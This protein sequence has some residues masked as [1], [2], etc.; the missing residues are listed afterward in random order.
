MV[1]IRKELLEFAVNYIWMQVAIKHGVYHDQDSLEEDMW[2]LVV[3][4]E[5]PSG[6]Y[7]MKEL[8]DGKPVDF[9][10]TP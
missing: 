2:K 3:D 1:E 10:P 7:E 6:W 5:L 4:G 8:L 9:N